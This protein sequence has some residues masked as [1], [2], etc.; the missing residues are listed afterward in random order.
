[1]SLFLRNF[2]ELFVLA[3]SVLILGRVLISW[4]DSTGRS[5]LSVFLFQVTEPIL[6][7][8]RRML[9]RTGMLDL[10]P[11]IVLIFLSFLLQAFR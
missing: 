11:M 2:L 3:I 8:V 6:A 7:P 5:R 1:V 9:P 4:I 10:A